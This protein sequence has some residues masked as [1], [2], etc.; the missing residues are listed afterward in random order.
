MYVRRVG[1]GTLR[2]KRGEVSRR[3]RRHLCGAFQADPPPTRS[4]V[5]ALY[6]APPIRSYK[7]IMH[8]NRR[9]KRARH[10]PRGEFPPR[11]R[12]L[13]MLRSLAAP[14]LR[15]LHEIRA[16]RWSIGWRRKKDPGR[17]KAITTYTYRSNLNV[18]ERNSTDVFL[19]KLCK[20]S[21][22]KFCC[23]IY[24]FSPLTLQIY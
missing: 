5:V 17:T 19:R 23:V 20:K 15:F 12:M 13:R 10:F 14:L 16:L 1:S 24:V 8:T 11:T 4:N 7:L 3:T 21:L 2:A 18:F 9:D 22:W 6:R